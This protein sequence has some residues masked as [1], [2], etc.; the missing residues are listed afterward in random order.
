MSFECEFVNEL[1][2]L[3]LFWTL[4]SSLI[5]CLCGELF[6]LS[7]DVQWK[8]FRKFCPLC[9]KQVIP[10]SPRRIKD[11]FSLVF[12]KFS[13][14]AL[15]DTRLGNF[16][17]T[18]KIRVKIYPLILQLALMRLHILIFSYGKIPLISP[19]IIFVQKPF[20]VGLFW[21]GTGGG[22]YYWREVCAWNGS[23]YIWKE[24]FIWKLRAFFLL[25]CCRKGIWIRGG[26]IKLLCKYYLYAPKEYKPNIRNAMLF[27][28]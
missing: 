6:I 26:R 16:V 18:L 15:V 9:Y 11:K 22:P 14:I 4:S 7:A 19:G 20:F 17:K 3:F 21:I 28:L 24:F 13:Q 23:A 2:K 27:G 1:D 25:K 8:V 5:N 10:M 12:S